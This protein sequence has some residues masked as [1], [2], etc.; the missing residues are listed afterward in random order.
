[1]T[2]Y[3]RIVPWFSTK[4]WLKVYN[5]LYC[6]TS[7]NDY[8]NAL[9]WLLIWKARCPSLPSGIESTLSLLDVYV[10]DTNAVDKT[11]DQLIRLAYSSAI[12]RFVNHMFDSDAA[13]GKSLYRIAETRGVPDWIVDL[14]HETAHSNNLPSLE[15]LR[16]ATSICLQWLHDN[17]WLLHKEILKDYVVNKNELL[18]T[19]LEENISSLI[20]VWTMLSFLLHTN[21]EVKSLAN[22]PLDLQK[23]LFN[24]IQDLFGSAINLSNLKMPVRTLISQLDT[25][26]G[27]MINNIN[28]DHLIRLLVDEESLVLS[29]KVYKAMS[30]KKKGLDAVYV[31]CF[32][33]FLQFLTSHDLLEE[34]TLEVIRITEKFKTNRAQSKLA[35]K[36]VSQIL[37]A[38]RNTQM[39][40][41][42]AAKKNVD[43]QNKTKKELL[44]LFHHWFPNAK[45]CPLFL[46]L[47]KPVPLSFTDINI[48]QP[49]I[50]NYNP[51]L[52]LFI[53]DL[54][55]LVRPK[56]PNPIKN[57]I[58]KLAL[59]IASPQGFNAKSDKIYT[60]EDFNVQLED[61]KLDNIASNKSVD[62]II[63]HTSDHEVECKEFNIWKKASRNHE[64]SSCP[65]GLLPWQ[66]EE[67]LSNDMDID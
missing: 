39:F 64:W 35:A 29:T 7:D 37:K 36:W 40:L 38:L 51:N 42:Q 6:T 57:R 18:T 20:S 15:L 63:P 25:F 32:E 56:L 24:D 61:M 49:I 47:K 9:K 5:S 16:E 43:V 30:T 2:D 44:S 3:Y 8:P 66:M 13:K 48:I 65:I 59:L 55:H 54:L 23:S 50:T 53:A 58:C 1:M 60:P 11:D 27:K 19:V 52:T 14:R 33:V 31:K 28:K 12:M 4:E 46:D 67:N 62:A 45:S 41:E 22:I 10:Q 17:Y 21:S 26:S 34:F